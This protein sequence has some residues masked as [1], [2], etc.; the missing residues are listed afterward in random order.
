V[1]ARTPVYFQAVDAKGY[2]VQ[3][4]RSWSTLQPGEN[5]SCVGCHE[6]KNCVPA[7]YRVSLA[8][9]QALQP[10]EP[11]YGPARGFSFPKE[12]QPILDRHCTRCH[13]DRQQPPQ[14]AA[15]PRAVG[16]GSQAPSPARE[17][18]RS[19]SL[20]GE[21]NL[22]PQAKRRWSDAYLALTGARPERGGAWHA[23]AGPLVN[24]VS[25]QSAPPMLPP[26][27]AGAATSGLMKLLSDGHKGVH[28]SREELDKIACWI[29]LLIPYCGDYR[30]SNAWTPE[31]LGRYDHFLAKRR[32]MEAI[33]ADNLREYLRDNG[34]PDGVR[35]A[36]AGVD[37]AGQE[38]ALSIEVLSAKGSV[39]ARQAG[40]AGPSR[41]LVLDVPRRY[42]PG[43]TVRVHGAKHMAVQFDA[44]LGETLIFAPEGEFDLAI[45]CAA[46]G[47]KPRSRP[48]PPEA[49]S[50]DRPRISL[51]PAAAREIDAYR[52]LA[53]NPY[54]VQG[55][56]RAFPHASSNS[57]CRH[58][59]VFAARNAIDGFKENGRHGGWPYQSWGP[60]Q[61]KDLWWQVD[62]GR[63]VEIDKLV[64]LIRTD[65]PHDKH[66]HRATLLF[67]DGGR[68][69]IDLE[70][71]AAPQTVVFASR[72]TTSVRLVDLAQDEPLGW[73]ALTEVEVWGRDP[74]AVA[75][76]SYGF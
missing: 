18:E 41:P 39:V 54:D 64:I 15:A 29:D 59:A 43:D 19:F 20:L 40:K 53:C 63:E 24:W 67:S 75:A 13:N 56:S 42:E 7:P 17:V 4:M 37:A 69:P 25:P 32:Q 11:F 34:N 46:P 57:E 31:E 27:S 28:L 10:L 6:S 76:A 16:A 62:F 47:V 8:Q 49:F 51:R 21:E 70:K 66:W 68:V 33:E 35:A 48:Y 12:I 38:V 74:V 30:Q 2:V 23:H 71:T 44:R 61:R 55:Q 65:F 9:R 58:E 73:C 50:A 45:P 1:P 26:Y 3:T 14:V 52:N 60:K 22:D 36:T 72:K 5:A